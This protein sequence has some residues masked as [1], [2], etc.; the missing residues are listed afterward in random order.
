[1]D[2]N[3][4]RYIF[5]D[6]DR[7]IVAS[8]IELLRKASCARFVKPAQLVSVGKAM[9]ALVRLP[10]PT[11]EVSVTI[12]LSSPRRR[13]DDREI[14]HLW[15]IMVEPENISISSG[16]HF[17]CESSGGD[18]FTSMQWNA[19]PGCEAE[20]KS[21]LDSLWMVDDAQPFDLEV[22]SVDLSVPGHS[23]EVF[24]DDNPLLD[25]DVSDSNKD[26]EE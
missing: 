19:W 21:Y 13:Y 5:D 20:Y 24:D 22:Q 9:H 15:E 17:Y 16:G 3:K 10:D 6:R 4:E 26:N 23:I 2:Q 12:Q 18:A 14:F 11:E 1:M 8:A 7:Q 25:E